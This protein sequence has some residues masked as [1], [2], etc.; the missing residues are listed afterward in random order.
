MWTLD[1]TCGEV[2]SDCELCHIDG[3]GTR[4]LVSRFQRAGRG[5]GNSG[6]GFKSMLIGLLEGKLTNVPQGNMETE[7]GFIYMEK[8][9]A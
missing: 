5:S 7:S 2:T 9:V 6:L 1:G 8:L 4:L 3:A